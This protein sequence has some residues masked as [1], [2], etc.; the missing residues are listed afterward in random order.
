MDV[1]VP[2]AS[3]V[4]FLL[5]A[6]LLTARGLDFLSTWIATPHLE[7]EANPIARKLGWR[8][9]A[10]LNG[11]VCLLFSQWPLPSIVIATTSVLVA[12]RN[13][14]SAWLMRSMGEEEY[15]SWVSSRLSESRRGLFLFCLFAQAA[16]VSAVGMALLYFSQWQLVPLGIGVGII[17]YAVAVVLFTLLS[18]SRVWRQSHRSPVLPCIIPTRT[19]SCGWPPTGT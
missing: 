12:A 8:W 10:V 19:N 4:Y 18:A 16:L 14:Q 1:T 6:L 5:L 11:A 2:F 3:P 13:F 17:A 9:G 15:R 7:L